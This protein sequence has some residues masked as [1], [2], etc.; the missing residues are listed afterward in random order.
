MVTIKDSRQAETKDITLYEALGLTK[1]DLL[2]MYYKLVLSRMLDE[3]MWVLNRQGKAPF[4]ISCQGHEVAG[5]GSIW[6]I[7]PGQD[8]VLPYYRDLGVV[9]TL[10][11]TPRELLLAVLARAGEPTS[12][13]KQMPAHYGYPKL[14]IISGSS[15]VAT[16]IPH[17]AG[18]ALA[19]KIKGESSVAIVYFGDGATSKGDFHEGINFAAI[20]KLPVIFVCENNDYAISVPHSKQMAIDNVSERAAAYGIPGVTVDGCDL[21]AVYQVTKAAVERGREGGGPTLIEAKVPRMTGHSSDDDEK[22]YRTQEEL[23]DCKNR[24][25]LVKTREWLMNEGILSQEKERE[26]R[27]KALAEIDDA[28]DFALNSPYPSPEEVLTNVY[29]S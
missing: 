11:M 23:E 1:D 10:G 20:H 13:A 7:E 27:D 16:Q 25:P 29:S 5:I 26:F 12:G 28:T 8:F 2:E 22:R 24:D 6:A 14:N 15:P 3:R 17:A 18:I 4:T 19:A 9:L 21:L